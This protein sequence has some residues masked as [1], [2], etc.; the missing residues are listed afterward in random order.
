M[1]INLLRQMRQCRPHTNKER[2]ERL[3]SLKPA[4]LTF[5]I[6]F[7]VVMLLG[8]T[9]AWYTAADNARNK[10]YRRT[11]DGNFSIVL[12]DDFTPP[13]EPPPPGSSFLKKVGAQNT[14]KVPGFVRLLVVPVMLAADGETVLPATLGTASTNTVIIKDMGNKWVYCPQD[15]YY[16]YLNRIDPNAPDDFAQ[17]LFTELTLSSTL[18]DEYKEA[19]LKI[20]VKCEAAGL[21]NYRSSWWYL[22]DNVSAGSPWA[23][24]DAALQSAKG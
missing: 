10:I 16:Y 7:V 8:S 20:E 22:A 19:T 13:E 14:G 21:D 3:N 12:V 18:G 17:N 5:A 24:I 2:F 1:K 9:L 6:L 15:G 4:I 11:Q 23:V